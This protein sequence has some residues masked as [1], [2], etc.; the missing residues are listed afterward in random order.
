[1]TFQKTALGK[2]DACISPNH[3][4]K[5]H[6]GKMS[7]I[8]NTE[9]YNTYIM[10]RLIELNLEGN[11]LGDMNVL[12][13]CD[14]LMINRTIRILNLSRNCLTNISTLKLGLFL[15]RNPPL[16]ELYLYWNRIQGKGGCN[17]IQ[18]LMKNNTLRIL[19]LA[20]NALGSQS[21][22][23]AKSVADL[24]AVNVDLIVFDLSNNQLGKEAA[25]QIADVLQ[26]NH[27]IYDF[28][29]QG[30][31]GY[32]DTYGFLMTPD[33]YQDNRITQRLLQHNI[34]KN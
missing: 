4:K 22:G 18:G 34:G 1:M 13:L 26:K 17:L 19:D 29:F 15:E 20:W 11:K 33:C 5:E 23:F 9:V 12:T 30:N 25:R 6:Q 16:K 31:Y 7:T 3:C 21:S 14:G 28:I 32:V 8:F 10:K 27:T 2:R 24:V